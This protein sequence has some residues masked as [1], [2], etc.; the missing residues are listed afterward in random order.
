M[1]TKFTAKP[2]ELSKIDYKPPKK[3]GWT[4]LL[5]SRNTP[6]A[7]VQKAKTSM[8]LNSRMHVTGLPQRKTGS[9]LKTGR[10]LSLKA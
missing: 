7:G 10:R 1:A 9:S 4:R 8:L 3:D 2:D 5:N 6:S